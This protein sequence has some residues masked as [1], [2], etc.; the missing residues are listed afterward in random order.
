MVYTVTQHCR[1]TVIDMVEE[2]WQ[3][4]EKGEKEEKGED[5]KLRGRPSLDSMEATVQRVGE[6]TFQS[7]HLMKNML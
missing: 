4:E 6:K 7:G 5:K 2:E 3:G 1:Q